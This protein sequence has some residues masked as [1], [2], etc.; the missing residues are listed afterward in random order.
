M[1]IHFL[2]VPI[3]PKQ[4]KIVL[5]FKSMLGIPLSEN[6]QSWPGHEFS[7]FSCAEVDFH[8]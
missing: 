2:D 7:K 3:C 6:M 4:K 1:P 8:Q 5:K